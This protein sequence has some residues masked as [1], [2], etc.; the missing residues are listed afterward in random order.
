[1]NVP[2]GSPPSIWL[3]C[4]RRKYQNEGIFEHAA[5]WRPVERFPDGMRLKVPRLGAEFHDVNF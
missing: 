1:M 5:G 4:A 2:G 3:S